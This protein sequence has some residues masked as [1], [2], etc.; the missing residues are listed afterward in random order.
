[1]KIIIITGQTATGKTQLALEYA[2]KYNGEL[3]N[4]DSRQTYKHLNIITGK[5]Y[6]K[7]TKIWLYDVVDPKQYFSSYD[8]VKKALPL[9]K[10]LL[11]EN[12]TPIIVGGTYFYLKHLLYHI[13]TE[14]IPPNWQLRKHL[15]N[16]SVRDLQKILKDINAQS[17]NRLNISDRNNPQRLIRK[18]EI[19]KIQPSFQLRELKKL[20]PQNLRGLTQQMK[21]EPRRLILTEKLNL[22]NLPIE[23]IGLRFKNKEALTSAIKNRVGERLKKGAID[24]VKELL[25]RG[26]KENDPGLKTIGYQQIIPYLKG[27]L[28]KEE[29]IKQWIIK[30]IQY[31]RR[32]YTFMKK[33][34]YIVWKTI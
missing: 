23:F 31:A 7:N 27:N 1:M 34:P 22:K 2:K 14:K 17:F 12:K 19:V 32:Q 16:K 4:C 18:I 9:I 20:V 25:Q 5:D 30:E 8:Y 3:V 21:I 29:A 13:E 10:K 26:Y 6:P 24:E 15:R 33:D 11:K 28:S